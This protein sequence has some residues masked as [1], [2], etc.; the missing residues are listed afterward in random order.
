[1]LDP[2]QD[3]AAMHARECC[4]V[5][6]GPSDE[7]SEGLPDTSTNIFWT[8]KIL[9]WFTNAPTLPSLC[10]ILVHGRLADPN[11]ASMKMCS[12]HCLEMI[13][14]HLVRLIVQCSLRFLLS[15]S[16]IPNMRHRGIHICCPMIFSSLFV[17]YLS[18]QWNWSSVTPLPIALVLLTPP[19]TIFSRLST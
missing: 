17:F 4:R 10:H 15:Q 6:L 18:N 5:R 2:L 11:K 19:V 14:S 1:M 16:S 13:W 9:R 7:K 12:I 8:D 3:H